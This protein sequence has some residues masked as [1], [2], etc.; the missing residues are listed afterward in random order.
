MTYSLRHKA[1]VLVDAD[2]T[3]MTAAAKKHGCTAASIATWRK[4]AMDDPELAGEYAK[5]STLVASLW[6]NEAASTMTA[7]LTKLRELIP[8]ATVGDMSIL[9]S[10]MRE[11][12]ELIVQADALVPKSKKGQGDASEVDRERSSDAEGSESDRGHSR[13]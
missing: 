7:F 1:R 8:E 4:D 11:C 3:S 6:R 2:C 5:A 9:I 13:H 10:G 12:G